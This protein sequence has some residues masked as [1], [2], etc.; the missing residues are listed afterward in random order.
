VMG[1]TRHRQYEN[2]GLG[3]GQAERFATYNLINMPFLFSMLCELL[4]RLDKNRIKSPRTGKAKDLDR[5]TVHNGIIPQRGLEAVASLSCLFPERRPD[6]S[7]GVSLKELYN[8][9]SG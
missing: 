3:I 6:Q 9:Q 1:G 2:L 8:G 4:D 7:R 5:R